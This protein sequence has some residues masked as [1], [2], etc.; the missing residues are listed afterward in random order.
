MML[1]IIENPRPDATTISLW[2]STSLGSQKNF[3]LD[4]KPGAKK[5]VMDNGG[6]A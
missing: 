2:S 3:I 4:Y 6:L 1:G 5:V